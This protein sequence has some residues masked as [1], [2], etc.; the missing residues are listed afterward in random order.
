MLFPA[1]RFKG[2]SGSGILRLW[3]EWMEWWLHGGSYMVG[4]CVK[5]YKK[6][7]QEGHF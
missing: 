2:I 4:E 3:G 7:S 1:R 6:I 5:I